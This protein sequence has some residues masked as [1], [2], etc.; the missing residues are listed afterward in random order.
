MTNWDI[1]ETEAKEFYAMWERVTNRMGSE[2]VTP[3]LV[4]SLNREHPTLRQQMVAQMVTLLNSIDATHPDGRDAAS[5]AFLERFQAWLQDYENL[6]INLK[7]EVRFP[8]I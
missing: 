2:D 8:F 6:Y 3:Y 1:G 4:E 5:C 7:G